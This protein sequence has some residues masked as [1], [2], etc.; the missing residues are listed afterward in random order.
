MININS[1]DLEIFFSNTQNE[2]N[3][4]SSVRTRHGRWPQCGQGGKRRRCGPRVY[5]LPFL[6]YTPVLA[7]HFSRYWCLYRANRHQRI[8]LTIHSREGFENEPPCS[9]L[10]CLIIVK[11]PVEIR[12]DSSGIVEN[13]FCSGVDLIPSCREYNRHHGDSTRDGWGGSRFTRV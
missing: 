6:K 4:I 8:S 5:T 7:L 3:F 10:P 9:L 13:S 11:N 12:Q 1:K 2:C